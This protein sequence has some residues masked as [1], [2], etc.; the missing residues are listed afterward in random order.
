MNTGLNFSPASPQSPT[1]PPTDP[2]MNKPVNGL[3]MAPQVAQMP[4]HAA[5]PMRTAQPAPVSQ[6]APAAPAAPVQAPFGTNGL[7][8]MAP[9]PRQ[10]PGGF[11]KL[12]QS[13]ARGMSPEGFAAGQKGAQDERMT[14]LAE[15]QEK[16]KASLIWMQQTAA[17]P[18]PQ[19]RAAFTLQNAQAIAQATGQP[20]DQVMQSATDPNAF[21]DES[22]QQGIAQF[23]A[24]AGIAPEKPEYQ[25]AQLGD[26]GYGVLNKATGKFEVVQ[27]PDEPE[28]KTGKDVN[29][30]ERYLDTGELV[31]DG[32]NKVDPEMT[33]YQRES[34]ALQRQRMEQGGGAGA[35]PSGYRWKQDGS[36]EKIPGGPA[37]KQASEYTPAQAG[38]YKAQASGLSSIEFALNEYRDA[39]NEH[40]T[41]LI[42]NPNDADVAKLEAAHNSLMMLLKSPDM[43]AL[44]VLT[45]P[46]LE[47]LE[48]SV[49][50]PTGWKSAGANAKTIG[51]RLNVIDRFLAQRRGQI[52]P[53]FVQAGPARNGQSGQH[54][55]PGAR[56]TQQ[57]QQPEPDDMDAHIDSLFGDLGD[58]EDAGGVPDGID[59]EDWNWLSPEEQQ[60][61]LAGSN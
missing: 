32:V 12:A 6:P 60:D 3:A 55:I 56:P 59:P 26:G 23:S 27:N 38:K 17:Q 8:A 47:L 1:V 15:M 30:Y 4:A 24:F 49:T 37:D 20:V 22:I 35:A 45:G 50:P 51:A 28:R 53:E 46:D 61:Y 54:L 5:P 2:R 39:V 43:F 16:A 21:S 57:A 25:G 48:K 10:Q 52:P 14:Q 13:F 11:G 58:G 41:K 7:A 42:A 18:T 31:F 33:P 29:G 40:G 9:K 19:A 44:G 34:L 36:L